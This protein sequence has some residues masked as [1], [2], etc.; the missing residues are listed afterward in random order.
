MRNTGASGQHR[1]FQVRDVVLAK[2]AGYPMWPAIIVDPDALSPKE[3]AARKGRPYVVRF[4][5]QGELCVMSNQNLFC[6]FLFGSFEVS[7]P[8]AF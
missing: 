1:M 2:L 6:R 7:R 4:I 5:D 8:T 3:R